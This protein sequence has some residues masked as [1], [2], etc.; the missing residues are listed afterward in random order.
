MILVGRALLQK[1]VSGAIP[2][3]DRERAMQSAV[4]VRRE[5][6]RS[7]DLA[8]VIV[9]ENDVFL[10][11]HALIVAR[12]PARRPPSNLRAGEVLRLVNFQFRPDHP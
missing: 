3:D 1:H 8:I 10:R 5:L 6:F 11:A 12:P 4:A 7:S 9:D 2:D